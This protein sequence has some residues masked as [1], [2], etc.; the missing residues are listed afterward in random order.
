[1]V[2]RLAKFWDECLQY[3][4][5][6]QKPILQIINFYTQ[7]NN[8]KSYFA[9]RIIHALQ[10]HTTQ[11]LRKILIRDEIHSSIKSMLE[12]LE[13]DHLNIKQIP[14]NIDNA[15]VYGPYIYT[16]LNVNG[17]YVELNRFDT[18]NC[19]S[20]ISFDNYIIEYNR[21]IENVLLPD[22]LNDYDK[23]SSK[24]L[25]NWLDGDSVSLPSMKLIDN[26]FFF[27]NL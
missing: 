13:F 16:L 18:F 22:E 23:Y 2:H 26:Q 7:F 15:M 27:K 17:I 1:M 19:E 8:E 10:T 9:A 5:Q 14:F 4:A 20:L 6:T 11:N 25:K 21:L 3:S 12:H 24:C